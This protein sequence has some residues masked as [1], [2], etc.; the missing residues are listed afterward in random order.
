[1]E[2]EIITTNCF[3][4]SFPSTEK[5][6]V[7]NDLIQVDTLDGKFE[8]PISGCEARI[9]IKADSYVNAFIGACALAVK[10][11]VQVLVKDRQITCVGLEGSRFRAEC[12]GLHLQAPKGLAGD[13]EEA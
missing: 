10:G 13:K 9:T 12:R 8:V 6:S 7:F 3:G 2:V 11:T 4:G 5:L 1:M